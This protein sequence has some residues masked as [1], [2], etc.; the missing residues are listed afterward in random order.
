MTSR[1]LLAGAL[2]LA[3]C[4]DTRQI[5]LLIDTT[6]GVPC[7]ID[8][9]RIVAK[10]AGTTTIERSLKDA[11]LPISVTLLDDTPSGRFTLEVSGL[12][13][14]VEVMRASGPLRF[15]GHEITNTV[16]LDPKCRADANCKLADAMSASAAVADDARQQCGANVTRYHAEPTVETFVNACT[17]AAPF[18]S[19]V[20][21]DGSS[22]P[23]RLVD[24][25]N[26]LP[27]FGFQF[28]GR[29]LRQIW[30]DKD[31]YISFAQEN[32][33][34]Y[35]VLVPGPLD[36]DIKRVGEPP[37]PQSVMAFWDTLTLSSAGVCYVL[38][39]PP[40]SQRLHVTWSHACLTQPCLLSDNLNNLTFTITLES[41]QRIV[42]TYDAMMAENM[43]R[44]HG[45]TATVGLAN[46]ATG[47][48]AEECTLATGLCKDGI[49][50]CG[51]SQVFSNTLQEH[52]RNMQF[53]PIADPE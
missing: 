49:T 48:P 21:G 40:M 1:W 38:E 8:G 41:P 30:L 2:A 6:A 10:A 53:V 7:D 51:Y 13:G 44:A 5:V 39:G 28:Y 45:A 20:L 50:P 12:K 27:N 23:V 46:N 9:I 15:S 31:G 37:P 34:P 17:A 22:K 19:K 25:E 29:P 32:P 43:E 11:R 24:L 16:L 42:V 36:R 35:G 4:T 52:V 3:A 26:L 18:T 33:D 47:C 14:N